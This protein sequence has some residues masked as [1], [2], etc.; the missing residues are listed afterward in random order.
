MENISYSGN[1]VQIGDTIFFYDKEKDIV[2]SEV[3]VEAV[4][5]GV[6]R[7]GSLLVIPDEI[8]GLKVTKIDKKAVLG[9]ESLNE[10]IIPYTVRYMENWSL[11]QCRNLK[12]VTI[13]NENIRFGKGVFDE[14]SA[15]E[16]I[17]IGS[18]VADDCSALMAMVPCVMEAEYLL[19]EKYGG[20]K[21]WY[22]NWDIRLI[23]VVGEADEDGY[24]ALILCGEEDVLKNPEEY[25]RDRRKKKAYLC[26]FR[27][28]HDS[29]L[30]D[31]F[32]DIFTDYV[33]EH[34]KGCE[35]DEAWQVMLESFADDI[36]Y[37]RMY[38]DMGGVNE[39]NI[40]DML[41]DMTEKH[42]E[43]KAYLMSYKEE[44][45]ANKHD[46]FDMFTL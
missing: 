27:L 20:K 4:I 14:C 2:G 39:N 8:E 23:S 35:T 6:S 19:S 26:L 3:I 21:A 1:T 28:F 42:T 5:T 40:D 15:L 44:H 36:A 16:H 30:D 45:L 34:I 31:E 29:D 11:A 25:C 37:Y 12:K 33:L 7:V 24:T 32:R 18:D 41:R 22:S 17:C 13:L 38:A 9:K 10:I 46:V 43:A